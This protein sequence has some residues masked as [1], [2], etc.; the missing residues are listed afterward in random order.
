[1]HYWYLVLC[2]MFF[3]IYFTNIILISY[4][5]K[6][7]FFN[8]RTNKHITQ[9]VWGVHPSKLLPGPTDPRTGQTIF[10][11]R[12]RCSEPCGQVRDRG[13]QA[14]GFVFN[15]AIKLVPWTICR[16]FVQYYTL[17]FL[18]QL[19]LMRSMKLDSKIV[20]DQI[21]CITDQPSLTKLP[22]NLVLPG[23]SQ[24]DDWG[25]NLLLGL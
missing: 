1:M 24:E 2:H 8:I 12:S 7:F 11:P 16:T 3:T 4:R 14:V 21:V 25:G 15:V 10:L 18:V 20:L 6:T 23:L 5:Q 19:D 9:V 17:T 13:M 22:P